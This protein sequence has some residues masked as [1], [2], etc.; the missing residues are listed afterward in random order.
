MRLI[1][2]VISGTEKHWVLIVLVVWLYWLEEPAGQCRGPFSFCMQK[3]HSSVTWE[4]KLSTPSSRGDPRKK[5]S[6]ALQ[7]YQWLTM[8]LSPNLLHSL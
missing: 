2:S 3:P 8:A 1:L 7:F 5:L 6:G 4:A